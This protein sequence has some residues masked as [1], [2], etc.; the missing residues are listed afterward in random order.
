MRNLGCQTFTAYADAG[1]KTDVKVQVAERS[2]NTL[3]SVSRMTECG[4]RV[5]FDVDGSCIDNES[6]GHVSLLFHSNGTNKLPLRMKTV[7]SISANNV[8]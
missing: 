6:A 7:E 8:A 3:S 4:D 1:I 5:V 2:N